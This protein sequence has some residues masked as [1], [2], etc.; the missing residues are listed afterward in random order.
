MGRVNIAFS[1]LN[2]RKVKSPITFIKNIVR[3]TSYS[4]G[5][6]KFCLLA[7]ISM[8]VKRN[9][10]SYK[11]VLRLLIVPVDN[12]NRRVKSSVDNLNIG[13]L[14]LVI[15]ALL[16]REEKLPHISNLLIKDIEQGDEP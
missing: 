6:Y 8:F 12:W 1:L 5:D 10:L 7:L 9:S 15:V 11:E 16:K 3:K 2:S 4:L 14:E 13:F